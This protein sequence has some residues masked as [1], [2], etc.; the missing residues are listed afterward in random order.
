MAIIT[1]TLNNDVILPGF[2][3]PGVTGGVPSAAD[4]MIFGGL[5]DDLIEGGGGN[6][7]LD[8]GDGN[9]S[10]FGG[11][12]ND[13]LIGGAGNDFLDPGESGIDT[14]SG[15]PGD[16][17]YFVA[18][19][20][21]V[22]LIE[23]PGEG[24]DTILTGKT[25]FRLPDNFEQLIADGTGRFKLAGNDGANTIVGS[26]DRDTLRGGGGD[27]ELFGLEG[28]DVLEG[29]G[30]AD[31]LTGGAGADRFVYTQVKDSTPERPDWIIDFTRGEDR[32]DLS[33]IDAD[34]DP[35][36][37]DTAF[38]YL[39]GAAFS[40]SGAELRVIADGTDWR[41]E[42]DVDGDGIA[43]LVIQVTADAGPKPG[44]FIL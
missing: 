11:A 38:A 15:G 35:S 31:R 16:D 3:S 26:F 24:F 14:A 21:T 34:G 1:G 44:W 6:D 4:D 36:N 42:A 19:G 8:G 13:T 17:R 32:I 25:K 10:L 9:D 12:G 27:D 43:D 29:S 40:G 2:V 22:T 7:T 30:G 41:V 33:A 23:L 20:A 5:G 37:G 18:A 39:G 28:N